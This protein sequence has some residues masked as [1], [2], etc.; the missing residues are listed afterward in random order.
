MDVGIGFLV[1][2]SGVP[3]GILGRDFLRF[4]DILDVPPNQIPP[5]IKRVETHFSAS[6]RRREAMCV[7]IVP[8]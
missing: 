7:H 6:S 5:H 3:A 2:K 8:A 4:G 1:V